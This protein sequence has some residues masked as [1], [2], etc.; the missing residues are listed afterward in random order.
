MSETPQTAEESLALAQR[1]DAVC[2]R[3]EDAWAAGQRPR[4]EDYLAATLEA[5]RPALLQELIPL[6]V[7]YR[8]GEGDKPQAAEYQ[9]RFPALDAAWVAQAVA[10]R[11]DSSQSAG[12]GRDALAPLDPGLAGGTEAGTP[13]VAGYEILGVLGRGA[14]G[15]VYR[16]RQVRLN[17]V[18]A[19]KMILAGEH[20][21][22]QELIRFRRE[23]EAVARLQH[24]HIVQIHEVG[25]Q[26]G[27]PYFSL[28]YVDGGSLAHTLAGTPQ[29]AK[30]AA[31][32]VETLAQAMHHAHQHGIVHRDLKPSN[33]L[34][35]SGG[36]VTGEAAGTT[37]PLTTY[38]PKITDFGLAKCLDVEG[39][40]TQSGALVGTPSYMAPEQALGQSQAIG[41]ATDVYALGAILYELL[42]GRP[43]F[44]AASVLDTLEQV[45]CH[46]PVP[47]GRLQPKVPRNLETI[48]LKA[49]AKE[50]GERYPTAQA[51]AD[52]LRRWQDGKPVQA[53][54]VSAWERAW[55]WARRRPA[56]AALV[57]VSGVAVLALVGVV[58]GSFYNAQ[59]QEAKNLAE[60]AQRVEA[61]AREE[62][63]R[64]GQIAE[65]AV[66][67]ATI[68]RAH[69]DWQRR[70]GRPR[71]PAARRRSS[72]PAQLGMALP[73][74]PVPPGPAHPPGT[75]Q[76]DPRCRLQ[77][78][79]NKARL[80]RL[81][82][83]GPG[84]G[85]EN[86]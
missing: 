20:A 67:Q 53:R 3:F 46:D 29:S 58:T 32:L 79:G 37:P 28:E 61:L 80:C 57:L 78:G 19:L 35:V 31:M 86:R 55:R 71:R 44:R 64:Q 48:C 24:P 17:R 39:G 30:Q 81:G 33:I 38:Q 50:P 7:Y 83:H 26:D 69:A 21:G 73:Q 59:L 54:P 49:L 14:M 52:D 6:E 45:R 60:D 77:P 62:A 12:S 63:E 1:L 70:Y 2:C 40:Q 47:P 72:R 13:T 22:P 16:A 43:P 36:V 10:P 11:V 85:R 9:A 18:V 51:L 5:D 8:R 23:A 15:V 75:Y 74:A 4:M 56:A 65:A 66:A 41:P 82:P 34:L 84:L 25:E 42:T 27:R 76:H 68:Y